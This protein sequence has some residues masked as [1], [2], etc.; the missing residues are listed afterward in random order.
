MRRC[1]AQCVRRRTDGEDDADGTTELVAMIGGR[2]LN[3]LR[4][5]LYPMVRLFVEYMPKW[6][7]R[8]MAL[9]LEPRLA[10]LASTIALNMKLVQGT[11]LRLQKHVDGE[12]RETFDE[13]MRDLSLSMMVRFDSKMFFPMMVSLEAKESEQSE[14]SVE[15]NVKVEEEKQKNGLFAGTFE[16]T[17]VWKSCQQ[18]RGKLSKFPTFRKSIAR[19]QVMS[20]ACN[21]RR[22][23]QNCSQTPRW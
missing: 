8:L 6:S 16:Q 5:E 7:R 10:A 9:A 14:R 20:R 12:D 22:V 19:A 15:V 2:L 3:S 21:G 1:N 11:R 18:L 13:I 23:T 4:E 17:E